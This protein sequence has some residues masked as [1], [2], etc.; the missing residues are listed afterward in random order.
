MVFPNFLKIA[1]IPL[2]H[3]IEVNNNNSK[4]PKLSRGLESS[5]IKFLS[6]ALGFKYRIFVTGDRE[7][8]RFTE[9][10][11]WTGVI[12]M[13]QDNETIFDLDTWR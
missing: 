11:T 12:G 13:V 10:G 9:N 4:N 6:E 5:I 2:R 8:G 1:V 7:W 3:I